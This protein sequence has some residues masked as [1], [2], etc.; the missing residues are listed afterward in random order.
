MTKTI[1]RDTHLP[2]G[3]QGWSQIFPTI[4]LR[5]S[6]LDLRKSALKNDFSVLSKDAL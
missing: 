4:N 1:V 2:A 6:A 3:R 5:K